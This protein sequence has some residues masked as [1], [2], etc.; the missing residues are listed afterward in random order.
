MNVDKFL[1]SLLR[2]D[3]RHIRI[4]KE[5]KSLNIFVSNSTVFEP[6]GLFSTE[7][8]GPVGAEERGQREGYIDLKVPII[9]PLAYHFLI[10]LKKDYGGII[11]GKIKAKFDPKLG[12]FVKDNNGE[13]GYQFF[14]EHVE[15]LKLSDNGS[16]ERKRNIE[17]VKAYVKKD[18]LMRYHIVVPAALRDYTI[19][20]A[21]RPMQDEINDLYRRL[22]VATN[23]IRNNKIDDKNL[24]QFDI[25][26]YKIQMIA[27]DI[28]EYIFA[29]IDGK[30]K[31]AQ[32]KF[33]ARNVLDGT[34]NVMTADPEMVKDLDQTNKITMNHTVC[35]LYQFVKSAPAL[36]MY[37][38]HS[39]FI[40][41]L[42]NP[43][44]LQATVIDKKTMK[45]T[46]KTITDKDRDRW[47]TQEGLN[48]LF[49]KLKQD[50][51][52]TDYAK[53][54]EDYVA[55]IEDRKDKIYLVTDTN[56][57]PREVNV[58]KLRPIT[59]AE[60]IY[61]SV[62]DSVDKV[63]CTN[64]RFPITGNGSFYPAYIYLKSTVIGRKVKLYMEGEEFDLPEFPVDGQKFLQS[65]SP[66]YSHLERL[67]GDYDGDTGT[68]FTLQTKEA[69][70]EIDKILKNKNYYLSPTGDLMFSFK[71]TTLDLVL[72]HLTS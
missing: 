40:L 24:Y 19:D 61:I 5:V 23:S 34:R 14:M 60:L 66:H 11:S 21:G 10:S 33:A 46:I 29:L 58:S 44:S 67:G 13:T 51:I 50:N 16:K 2:L 32:D 64:T 31:I 36:A 57:I 65:F 59:Y 72:K 30:K 12:D 27:Q 47:L 4:L 71:T 17:F 35:G 20:A 55:L 15:D 6:T 53:I 69:V 62:Y 37:N 39:K 70:E 68:M 54:G 52:K 49:N 25:I 1:L 43:Y 8:F 18:L 45:T 9:L 42:L 7:I 3:E 26:R 22:I 56:D 41:K 28:L 48:S 38:V 63:A